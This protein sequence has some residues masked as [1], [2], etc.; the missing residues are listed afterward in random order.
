MPFGQLTHYLSN[1]FKGGRFYKTLHHRLPSNKLANTPSLPPT[2]GAALDVSTPL[3]LPSRQKIDGVPLSLLAR[4]ADNRADH[5]AF[6][7][8]LPPP[9]EENFSPALEICVSEEARRTDRGEKIAKQ[10]DEKKVASQLCLMNPD[11]SRPPKRREGRGSEPIRCRPA[12]GGVT[13]LHLQVVS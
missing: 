8:E 12:I 2:S 7:W 4:S 6:S 1:R 10:T 5:A 11:K 3:L 9:F 13:S